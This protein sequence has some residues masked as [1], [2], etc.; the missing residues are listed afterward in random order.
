MSKATAQPM[1]LKIASGMFLAFWCLLAAF[2]IV[3]IAIM[4]VKSPR[5]A[6]AASAW[7][8]ITGP[9][10]RAAGNGLSI[11]DLVLGLAFLIFAIRWAFAGLPRMIARFSPP[12]LIVLGWIVGALLFALGFIVI[13]FGVLPPVF[14]ALNSFAGPLGTPV[15]GLTTEHYV[16]VWGENEFYRNFMNSMIVT[17]GVVTISL[18]VGTLAGY[19]LARSGSNLAFWL[20]ILALIFR[21]LPH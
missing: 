14:D 7:D 4:S 1:S 3:W 15:I 17:A 16:S 11:L 9:A 20:L 6:F 19:G 10:T 13:F 12:G 2:P 5:D 18:T 21:A 8:V